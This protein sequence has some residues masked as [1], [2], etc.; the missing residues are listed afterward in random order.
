MW[1]AANRKLGKRRALPLV[2]LGTNLNVQWAGHVDDTSISMGRGGR[3]GTA[4]ASPLW[5]LY[6]DHA[7]GPMLE[8]YAKKG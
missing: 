2:R 8:S 7:L 4:E 6:L 5:E 1:I 3:Q